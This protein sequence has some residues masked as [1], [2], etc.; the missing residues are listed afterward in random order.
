MS[1]LAYFLGVF[2]PSKEIGL[3][4]DHGRRILINI[5]FKKNRIHAAIFQGDLHDL[6]V[7]E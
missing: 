1:P 3:L 2:K 4:Q 6:S 7:H 5:P